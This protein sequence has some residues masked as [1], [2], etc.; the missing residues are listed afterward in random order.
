[1]EAYQ[2]LTIAVAIGGVLI[3]AGGLIVS[4]ISLRRSSATEAQTLR[5]QE[6]Q[7]E[8]TELQLQ[9]HKAEVG[10]YAGSVPTDAK[11]RSADI[12]VSLEG[13]ARHSRFVIRNWGYGSAKDIKL[14]VYPLKGNSSPLV[15]GDADE[16]LPIPRL[17]PGSDCSIIAALSFDT[18]STF[19]V[20]WSWV[21]EDGSH[22][23]ESSR[24]SL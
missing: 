24:I 7:E 5:L 14:E 1:M 6:K 22:R 16:K 10:K 15:R 11:H 18:G 2:V 23:H 20:K 19:D 9:L 3:A 12:R 13:T 8:L 21:D 4:I 17:S